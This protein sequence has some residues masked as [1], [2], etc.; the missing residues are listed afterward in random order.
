MRQPRRIFL[1]H[2]LTVGNKFVVNTDGVPDQWNEIGEGVRGT[3]PHLGR[4]DRGVGVPDDVGRPVV[5]RPS[6]ACSEPLDIGEV[7]SMLTGLIRNLNRGDFVA[8]LIKV[9][10]PRLHDRPGAI[11]I[12]H[13]PG[14]DE[15]VA[16]D[17]VDDP[18]VG[19]AKFEYAV[20]QLRVGRDR[21]DGPL[22]RVGR[23][24]GRIDGVHERPDDVADRLA[25]DLVEFPPLLIGKRKFEFRQP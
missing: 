18:I 23:S 3:V 1:T 24:S 13:S 21:L 6:D 15:F 10:P 22:D 19:G 9:D 20:A 8:M 25:S 4:V 5:R 11:R 7:D 2:P 16:A 12:D 14:F 17:L